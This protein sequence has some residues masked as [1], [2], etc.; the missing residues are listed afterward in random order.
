MATSIRMHIAVAEGAHYGCCELKVNLIDLYKKNQ[1][2]LRR[3]ISKMRQFQKKKGARY[4]GNIVKKG[5]TSKK[6][7][8]ENKYIIDNY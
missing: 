6:R 1:V 8:P 7:G 5:C 2:A 3:I 4:A